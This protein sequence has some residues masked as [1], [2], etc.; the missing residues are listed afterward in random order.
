[1]VGMYSQATQVVHLKHL[2]ILAAV[3][4]EEW[5]VYVMD[6]LK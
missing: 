4:V 6:I 1:M 3:L 2:Q 5:A